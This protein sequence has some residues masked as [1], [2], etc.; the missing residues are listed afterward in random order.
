MKITKEDKRL[1]NK[2]I[3]DKYRE[4][5]RIKWTDSDVTAVVD[6]PAYNRNGVGR[7][8]IGDPMSLIRSLHIWGTPIIEG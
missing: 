6:S 1:V 8:Y 7:I 5:R 4:A 2:A 3:R